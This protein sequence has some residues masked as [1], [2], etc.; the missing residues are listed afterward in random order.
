MAIR[1]TTTKKAPAKK[2]SSVGISILGGSKADMRKWEIESAMSTLQRAAE[3]QKNAKLMNDVK[4]MAAEKAKKYKMEKLTFNQMLQA[5]VEAVK[6]ESKTAQLYQAFTGRKM[7][8]MQVIFKGDLKYPSYV[9][10]VD[11]LGDTTVK[12][13]SSP[14]MEDLV[15]KLP[16]EM[17][18]EESEAALV[19][20]GYD[21]KWTSITLRAPLYKVANV[22][23]IAVDSTDA[24]NVFPIS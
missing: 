12:G 11:S 19:A 23:F 16:L 14:Y 15:I 3:I 20:A 13:M 17:T 21:Q 10:L 8:A 9:V 2:S 18:Q 4:K 5:A 6:Q 22:G 7:N 1:K 24:T